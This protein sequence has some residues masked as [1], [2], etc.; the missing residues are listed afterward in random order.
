MSEC[1]DDTINR[2][3]P[4][5]VDYLQQYDAMKAWLDDHYQMPDKKVALLIR[6]LEQNNGLI[7]NRA[8]EKEFV[9]L[10][11]EDIQSI[12]DNYRLCFN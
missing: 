6:F 2:I 8:K 9:E 10:T 11:N 1:I 5:E 12:E 7:S 4:D 3:I